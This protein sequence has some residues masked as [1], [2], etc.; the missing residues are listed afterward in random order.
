MI[1]G[2]RRVEIGAEWLGVALYRSSY[3]KYGTLEVSALLDAHQVSSIVNLSRQP[4]SRAVAANIDVLWCPMTGARRPL[5][6]HAE[7][8]EWSRLESA[9][10]EDVVR[11][12]HAHAVSLLRQAP[13][14]VAQIAAH[15]ESTSRPGGLLIHCD[16]GKDRT[17]LVIATLQTLGSATQADVIAEYEASDDAL[18]PAAMDLI[19]GSPPAYRE[20]VR[21]LLKCHGVVLAAAFRDELGD[22]SPLLWLLRS[23]K[24][25]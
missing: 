3:P 1:A 2:F 16:G 19:Q 25:T 8:G 15:L 13:L 18:T 5:L 4:I 14:I 22:G 6:E 20:L 12:H 17:G 21:A 24:Q 23:L 11:E 10:A 9:T 7:A